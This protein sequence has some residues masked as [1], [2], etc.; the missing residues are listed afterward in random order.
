MSNGCSVIQEAFKLPV[1]LLP[2]ELLGGLPGEVGV[3]A[4]KVA[5]A[6][7]LGVDGALEVKLA[8][9]ASSAHVK[10]LLDELD[11]LLLRDLGSAV[12]L[13]VDG[14]GGRDSDSVGELDEAAAADARLDE[15][16]G[17]PAGVVSGR[18]VDLGGVLSGEG[19]SSVGSPS[20]VGVDDDLTSGQSGIT[21]GSSDDEASRGVEHVLGVGVQVLGRDDGLD[22]V[23]HEVLLDLLVG[24]TILVLGGD[25]HGV[26]ALG[27][28]L[29]VNLL[30]LHRH[31][32]LSV[33][34]DPRDQAALANLSEASAE[35]GGKEVGHGHALIGLVRGISEH[36]SLVTSANVLNGTTDVNS[37]GNVR[38]L[39]LEGDDDVGSLVVHAL[40]SG[41]VS[42]ALDGVADDLLVVDLSLGGDLAKDHDHASLARGLA[43][44]LGVRVG[45]EARVKD[46]IGDDVR[47]LVGVSLVNG[48]GGE[49]VSALRHCC[50]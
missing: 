47:Q 22:D 43:G 20:S 7:G 44:D 33:G 17:D 40:L 37:L 5:V 27:D 49:E 1:T 34:A 14:D 48:L 50:G 9:E 26:D 31:L 28:D 10:V 45:G 15:G 6:A 21:V 8:D 12:G 23:L 13:D 19:T 39:L 25:E 29:S 18:A 24:D 2:L 36:E 46:G 42:N 3:V 16:L 38:G 35:L 11:D 41:V 32:D 30:D 4:S